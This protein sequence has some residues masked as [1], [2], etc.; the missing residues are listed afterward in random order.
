MRMV[1]WGTQDRLYPS[2]YRSVNVRYQSAKSSSKGHSC[3][4]Q[5][6]RDYDH[7]ILFDGLQQSIDFYRKF[8]E[9]HPNDKQNP[10]GSPH[11]NGKMIAMY[12]SKIHWPRSVCCLTENDGS[13]IVCEEEQCRLI[14]FSSRLMLLSTYGGTRGNGLDQFDSP[15]SVAAGFDRLKSNV[16][17]AD[18]NNRRVLFLTIGFQG[19]F[20]Y[21]YSVSIKE[22][23]FFIAISREHF[24]VS[25]EKSLIYTFRT[26]GTIP[27]ATIDLNQIFPTPSRINIVNSH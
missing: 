26:D 23:P 6:K 13:L 24:A 17:V 16:L 27:I 12:P 20:R 15:W 25:C 21:Q 2:G 4:S 3:R 5:S 11:R 9:D 1:D 8:S 10:F 18:S 19:Q 22:K 14:H 7:S